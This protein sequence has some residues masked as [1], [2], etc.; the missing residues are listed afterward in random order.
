MFHVAATS[1]FHFVDGSDVVT[2]GQ[3]ERVS[4]EPLVDLYSSYPP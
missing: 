4:V 1:I 2:A 3:I